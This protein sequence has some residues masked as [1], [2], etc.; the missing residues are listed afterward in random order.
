MAL[1]LGTNSY[2]SAGDADAYFGD[3]PYAT[4][5]DS[6]PDGE[7]L[8]RMAARMLDGQ[9]YAGTIAS[10]AQAMAWPRVGVT[11]IEGR[12]IAADVIP[13]A[14]KDAQCE[15]ALALARTDLTDDD[16]K[17]LVRRTVADVVSIEYEPRTRERALPDFVMSLIAPFLASGGGTVSV[18]VVV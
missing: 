8:L 10:A 6:V 15:L 18:R 17:A 14:I 7:A 13:Q 11:D 1:I 2:V 16:A 4:D 3:R 9:R 5:W 12:T